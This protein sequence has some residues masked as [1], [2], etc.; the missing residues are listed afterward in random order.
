[1]AY[2]YSYTTLYAALS[3]LNR[4]SKASAKLRGERRGEEVGKHEID[5][6][7]LNELWE[8]QKGL[9]FYSNIPM[10]YNKAEWRVSIERLDN[11]KG[12]IPENVV[13]CCLEFNV[14][15]Q[16]TLQKVDEIFLLQTKQNEQ[17]SSVNFNEI[18]ELHLKEK[19]PYVDTPRGKLIKLISHANS[20]SKKRNEKGRNHIVN[21]TIDDLIELYENQ[22]GLCAY[23]GIPLQF[24]S[25][26]KK[27]WTVSLERLDPMQGYTKDNIALICT[28]FNS[29]DQTVKTGPEYGSA[30]WNPLKY[31]YFIAHVKHKKGEISD[32]ELQATIQMQEQFKAYTKEEIQKYYQVKIYHRTPENG[33]K[34]TPLTKAK[35]LY[36]AIYSITSPSGKI[37]ID[38]TEVLF[39]TDSSIFAKMRKYRYKLISA[40]I[41]EYGEN[42]M[43]IEK[44]VSCKKEDLDKYKE[45]FINTLNTR[46]PHGLNPRK[47]VSR[48]TRE[49]ISDT[50]V[51]NTVRYS[52]DDKEL[53]KYVKYIDWK[54]RKGYAVVNHPTCKTKYFVSKNKSLEDL[55]TDCVEFLYNLELIV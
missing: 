3:V 6:D 31:D 27:N 17:L 26:L 45:Y 34:I 9:C 22:K 50:L 48:T 5:V 23:S 18:H 4:S 36:G 29:C 42:A 51:N 44:L 52:H 37:F 39:Q 13:L 10:N 40:E 46:E 14:V 35:Q 33:F 54:D 55:Y 1:M 7:F 24:G 47:I 41:A 8:K 32:E 12:Y 11:S 30:A 53:P 49:Q 20:T 16:W 15:A 43:K 25:Y 28:E 2:K 19:K 21:I 38:Q